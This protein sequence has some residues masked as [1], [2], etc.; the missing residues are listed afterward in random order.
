MLLKDI[1]LSIQSQDRAFAVGCGYLDEAVGKV[2]CE[3]YD[4]VLGMLV[5]MATRP[6]EGRRRG[7]GG[8]VECEGGGERQEQRRWE[9]GGE[10]SKGDDGFSFIYRH[11]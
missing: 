6:E 2:F 7:R 5:K 9:R 1:A 8:E 4:G 10:K 11:L 3:A